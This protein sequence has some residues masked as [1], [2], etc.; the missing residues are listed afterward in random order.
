MCK[1]YVTRFMYR[2]RLM[3]IHICVLVSR[4]RREWTCWHRASGLLRRCG[5]VTVGLIQTLL[6]TVFKTKPRP[7]RVPCVGS[8]SVTKPCG[9]GRSSMQ[10]TLK[11]IGQSRFP[12]LQTNGCCN[13]PTQYSNPFP[14]ILKPPLSR[15]PGLR[16][17][18]PTFNLKGAT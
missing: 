10:N 13:C 9:T 2:Q 3:L 14:L 18:G 1:I 8:Y 11:A 6:L 17:C 15:P 16:G 12:S 5:L 7:A 4:S